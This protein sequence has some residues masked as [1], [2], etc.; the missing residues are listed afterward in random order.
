[1]FSFDRLITPRIISV[2]Y[3]LNLIMF[4]IAA[5]L[6]FANGKVG[7]ALLLVL[8]AVMSR[9]FFECIMIAFKNNEYL[10]RMTEALENKA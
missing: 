7:A 8:F 5:I 4:A 10:R 1:M 2:L 6:S 9:V 3:I